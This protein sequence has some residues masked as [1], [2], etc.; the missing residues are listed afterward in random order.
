VAE[1]VAIC[2]ILDCNRRG[3]MRRIAE[4]WNRIDFLGADVRVFA[5]VE[6]AD[7]ET[8]RAFC[9]AIRYPVACINV[10]GI[11][12]LVDDLPTAEQVASGNCSKPAFLHKI[13]EYRE[14]CRVAVVAPYS[15]SAGWQD[16]W[17]ADWL[18]W[19]DS[20]VAPIPEAYQ[21][22]RADHDGTTGV[23]AP[24]VYAGLY[25]ERQ[26]G[27]SIPQY[28]SA[29][30][31]VRVQLQAN[32]LQHA[33]FAGFGCVLMARKTA[34]EN[35]WSE[36]REYRYD[37]R[38]KLEQGDGTEKAGTLGEDVWWFRRCEHMYGPSLVIDTRVLCRH[39]HR[40]GSF[41]EHYEAGEELPTRYVTAEADPAE[42]VLLHNIGTASMVINQYQQFLPALAAGGVQSVSPEY[43]EMLEKHM[44]ANLERLPNPARLQQVGEQEAAQ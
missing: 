31:Q 37:R 16:G 30:G 14:A 35:G 23:M 43:A 28:R 9:S 25:C 2:T 8:I 41:W 1:C 29:G 33:D 10:P 22:L 40:D 19:L 21:Y 20:D 32:R 24:V 27:T 17:Q 7:P 39:Y 12:D 42:Q 13:A 36:Y 15:C 11:R 5:V 4:A 3:L 38:R 34:E 18:L 6:D 44:G 26:T